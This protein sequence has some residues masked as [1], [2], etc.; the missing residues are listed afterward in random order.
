MYIRCSLDHIF[1]NCTS[2]VIYVVDYE[3]SLDDAHPLDNDWK[4]VSN[5]VDSDDITTNFRNIHNLPCCSCQDLCDDVNVC[6]CLSNCKSYNYK[7]ELIP[8][9]QPTRLIMECNIRCGC[10]IRY[11]S[12]VSI[13]IA[14]CYVFFAFCLLMTC[15]RCT[16]RV[17]QRGLTKRLQIYRVKNKASLA[18]G[19]QLLSPPP[20]KV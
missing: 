12:C 11:S 16:N 14:C 1:L 17:V 18:Q 3:N 7:G 5:N 15:R 19:H 8:Y 4:Y 20:S 6:Q 10:S 9:P 13:L 2:F